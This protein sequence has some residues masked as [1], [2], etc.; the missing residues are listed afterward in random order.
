MYEYD[1]D[2][3]KNSLSIDQVAE[4]VAELG[5]EPYEKNGVLLLQNH[6]PWRRKS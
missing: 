5:G 1:K 3:L 4:Y 2:G 6:L